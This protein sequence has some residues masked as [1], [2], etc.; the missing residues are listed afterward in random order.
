MPP[1]KPPPKGAAPE[2]D[3]EIEGWRFT[4]SI[5]ISTSG[6]EDE[7]QQPFF[8]Y[9]M[10]TGENEQTLP[11]GTEGEGGWMPDPEPE[12]DAPPVPPPTYGND[13]GEMFHYKKNFVVEEVDLAFA[14]NINSS[15][16]LVFALGD[17]APEGTAVVAAEGTNG[18]S[19]QLEALS[20]KGAKGKA[21]ASAE[22]PEFAEENPQ[23][24]VLAEEGGRN[25]IS[26][27]PLDLSPLLGGDT[28]VAREF[29]ILEAGNI[30]RNLQFPPKGIRRLRISVAIQKPLLS[31]EL[32]DK[33]NPLKI[34]LTKC[35]SIPGVEVT[36][37]DMEHCLEPTPYALL[38]KFCKP[39]YASFKFFDGDLDQRVVRTVAL[40]HGPKVKWGHQTV[41]LAGLMNR[42]QVEENME[43][44]PITVELHDRDVSTGSASEDKWFAEAVARWEQNAVGGHEL[45]DE[46]IADIEKAKLLRVEEATGAL[47]VSMEDSAGDEDPELEKAKEDAEFALQLPTSRVGAALG[48]FEAIKNAFGDV[49]ERTASA[50]EVH[51]HGYGAFRLKEL[52]DESKML[53]Q[54]YLKRT[55]KLA[56]QGLSTSIKDQ[57]YLENTLQA[58]KAN[59]SPNMPVKVKLTVNICQSKR[60]KE[61]KGAVIAD[62]DLSMEERLVRRPAGFMDHQCQ[63]TMLASLAHPIRSLEESNCEGTGPST[64][65]VP[66][67]ARM[68]VIL[69]YED[70][71]L[72]MHVQNAMNMVNNRALP[73][74]ASLKSHKLEPEEFKAAEEGTLP[75]GDI[76][77]GFQLI[78]DHYRMIVIE[79]LADHGMK[80]LAAL[81]PRERQNDEQTRIIWNPDLRFKHRLYAIFNVDMKKVKLRDPLPVISRSPEIYNRTKVNEICFNCVQRLCA[82]RGADRMIQ[83]KEADMFPRPNMLIQLEN[84]YGESISLEDIEGA[85]AIPPHKRRVNTGGS[86]MPM[87]DMGSVVMTIRNLQ[88]VKKHLKA[89]TD[90]DN[91]SYLA[92]KKSHRPPDRLQENLAKST[93]IMKAHKEKVAAWDA[94]PHE[95]IWTY[96]GQKLQFTEKRKRELREK[97]GNDK[98][99]TYTYS[100]DF[101]SLAMEI[102][103][104][105]KVVRDEA[106]ESQARW[107]T[108]S[109]FVYPKPKPVEEYNQHPMQVTGARQEELRQPWVENENHPKPVSRD[110][111]PAEG[112][113]LFNP[114]PSKD[115][116]FG[117]LAEPDFYAKEGGEEKNPFYFQSVFLGG[118]G[119]AA[120]EAAAKEREHKTFMSKVVVDNLDFSAHGN[121]RGQTNQYNNCPSQ[122]DKAKD[123]RKGDIDNKSM[124]IV[125]NVRVPNGIT[126]KAKPMKKFDLET[127]P[128]AAINVDEFENPADFTKSMRPNLPSKWTGGESNAFKNHIHHELMLPKSLKTKSTA[129]VMTD[130]GLQFKGITTVNAS[131]K[132]GPHW[133]KTEG[134]QA[135]HFIK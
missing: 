65:V 96:S 135:K 103:D 91:S 95:K 81:V 111:T 25:F 43:A 113:P 18:I 78:D 97:Y 71:P 119:M 69:K 14:S 3:E 114:L 31:P 52:L 76:I 126:N 83:V 12:D 10:P 128:V 53:S 102:V 50:G 37:R 47:A 104:E 92:H 21:P 56:T 90:Q 131:E 41:F 45:T 115:M 99:A 32:I 70:T 84:K 118:E 77:T 75:L 8:R 88:Q 109:G 89:P 4:V 57:A 44:N 130:V 34:E 58:E 108:N 33:L 27:I 73:H 68:M 127:N 54:A 17:L 55:A 87:M 94:E 1:K 63:M 133:G 48:I 101:Q 107:T 26:L 30:K 16:N 2:V 40:P 112:K 5:D 46:E 64:S 29:A 62:L 19:S 125:S 51:A 66:I 129:A 59:Q 116:I 38:E 13:W 93:A 22:V 36:S 79:G 100:A 98:K 80:D 39:V 117:A 121:T 106:A 61:P 82:L 28:V 122:L 35:V 7:L 86:G 42:Q 74:N 132:T 24:G 124:R 15:P 49:C 105:G 85:G 72:L 20:G 23:P 9:A 11:L 120:E 67:F 123:V 110:D 60:R 6:F 134:Q